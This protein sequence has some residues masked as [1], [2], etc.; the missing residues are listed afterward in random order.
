MRRGR[1]EV[2][3][4]SKLSN[5]RTAKERTADAIDRNI[6][7]QECWTTRPDATEP[8]RYLRAL[9]NKG[10]H[11]PMARGEYYVS[12]HAK[13][14]KVQHAGT[15][16]TFGTSKA[17]LNAAMGA[18]TTAGGR[19]FGGSVLIQRPSG[20]WMTQWTYGVDHLPN[21]REEVVRSG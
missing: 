3:F 14:W 10:G 15:D 18:A 4:L 2:S 19:G 7:I 16:I 9:A 11:R 20:E 12:Q 8:I 17:A 5:V 21:P 1:V 13:R 6:V